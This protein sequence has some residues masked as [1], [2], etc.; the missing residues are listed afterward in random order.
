MEWPTPELAV[1]FMY[2]GVV[3]AITNII[4]LWEERFKPG[5]IWFI[6]AMGIGGAWAMI[7]ATF[8]LISHTGVTLALGNFFWALIPA[9]S[10]SMFLAAYEYVFKK[11]VS[12]Q[13]IAILYAPVLGLFVLSWF[14]PRNLVFTEAYTVDPNGY[15]SF[16]KFGGPIKI[17]VTKVYG[18]VL[19]FLGAGMFVGEVMRSKGT[20]RRQTLYVLA[21]LSVLVLATL[22]KVTRQV[23][24][25][26]DPTPVVFSLSGLAFA[27]SIHQG[28]LL[29]LGPIAREQTFEDVSEAIFVVDPK[30]LIIDANTIAIGIFGSETIGR[31]IDAVLAP[32]EAETE[33][34][35]R[36]TV[37]IQREDRARIFAKQT[38]GIEYGRGLEGELVVLNEI[39]AL[40][41]REEELDLLKQILTR[42]LRHNIRNDLNVIAGYT[43]FIRDKSADEEISNWADQIGEKAEKVVAHAE[44]VRQIERVITS[45]KTVK[46]S[47]A[48]EVQAVRKRLQVEP[49]TSLTI[50]VADVRVT[51]HPEFQLAIRELI[52]NAISHHTGPGDPKVSL[53]TELEETDVTLIVEDNGPGLP[54]EE[55]DVLEAKEETDLEHS[56]GIGLW[57][58]QWIVSRSGGELLVEQ[59]EQG[60]RI[61]IRLAIADRRA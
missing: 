45:G 44:K 28:G 57:L 50:D 12:W 36:P 23:P 18:Y 33:D 39:T 9:A 10:V 22:V 19:V 2:L 25:Y 43:K 52:D 53:T 35:E 20:H 38:S 61:G 48:A 34:E 49:A 59:D 8:T 58:V 3:P 17:A 54:E 47:L 51:V 1:A 11:I 60:T 55:I 16:P 32:H 40:K 37:R 7:F 13:T 42:V 4:L 14:N 27:I 31:S 5:V 6:V 41:E 26:F 30:G 15:L 46:R 29:K 21:F 56:S 24:I